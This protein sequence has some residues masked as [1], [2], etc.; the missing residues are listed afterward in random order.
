[1]RAGNRQEKEIPRPA[2]VRTPATMEHW[3]RWAL[4]PGE[5]PGLR[6]QMR[7][8]GPG[9]RISAGFRGQD[10]GWG[11]GREQSRMSPQVPPSWTSNS[12]RPALTCQD[13]YSRKGGWEP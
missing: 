4:S 1:M 11:G 5:P 8:P 3:L 6:G 7:G 2:P 9:L 10:G 12:R 13:S